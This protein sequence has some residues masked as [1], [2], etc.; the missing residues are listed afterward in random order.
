MY[1]EVSAHNVNVNVYVCLHRIIKTRNYVLNSVRIYPH[2]KLAQIHRKQLEQIQCI[3]RLAIKRRSFQHI[4]IHLHTSQRTHT[5][6]HAYTWLGIEVNE[7]TQI[8]SKQQRTAAV[9]ELQS[10]WFST[11]NCSVLF[12]SLHT[13]WVSVYQYIC[14]MFAM[15]FTTL[16]TR[17]LFNVTVC[18]AILI[19]NF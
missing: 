2:N 5:H 19:F 17:I 7:Q 16:T 8:S 14:R 1:Y 13:L 10:Q 4:Y 12:C 18:L 9:I 3:K 15:L 11:C 6:T